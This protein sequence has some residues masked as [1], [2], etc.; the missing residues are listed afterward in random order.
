MDQAALLD[1]YLSGPGMLRA[2][3]TGMSRGQMISRPIAGRWSGLE[4]VC[5]LVETDANTPQIIRQPTQHS[6]CG[7]EAS[8]TARAPGMP[9]IASSEFRRDVA[10]LVARAGVPSTTGGERSRQLVAG[11]PRVL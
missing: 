8:G 6:T 4:V 2:A 9:T 3:V 5:H 1:A 11:G 10:E 7:K